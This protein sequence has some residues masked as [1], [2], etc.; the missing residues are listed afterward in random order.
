MNILSF[1]H[2]LQS[3]SWATLIRES[4]NVFP[5]LYVLHIF[6]FVM[7]VTATG[8]LDLRMLGWGF[9]SQSVS[10]LA[11]MA[12]PWAKVG[13]LVNFLTGFILFATNAVSMYANT[14][15]L[16]KMAMVLLAGVNIVVFQLTTYRKVGE[17]G[18]RGVTPNAAKLTAAVSLLLWVG[19][20]AMSRVIGFT[21]TME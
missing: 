11:G 6:G 2:W 18:E 14:A 16:V 12:I 7:I 10:G 17:W 5:A 8:V 1:C 4:Y 3:T 20:V 13:F 9:R 21:G 15:F 19:I